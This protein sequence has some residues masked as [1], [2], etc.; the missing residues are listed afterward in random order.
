MHKKG[1][2]LIELLVVIAIIAILAAILLPA[3]ARAREAARRASCQNNLKQLG[4]VLK[5][6]STENKLFPARNYRIGGLNKNWFS[7]VPYVPSFDE[8]GYY[9]GNPRSDWSS[10]EGPGSYDQ[11]AMEE[12]WPDYMNDMNIFACPSDN[13]RPHDFF[14]GPHPLLQADNINPAFQWAKDQAANMQAFMVPIDSN[15]QASIHNDKGYGPQTWLACGSSWS[16]MYYP[17]AIKGEWI[18]NTTNAQEIVRLWTRST[19]T[20]AAGVTQNTKYINRNKD[21]TVTLWPA[22]WTSNINDA[23]NTA[24]TPGGPTVNL[25]R[26]REGI[27]RFFITDINN[28][29]ASTAAQS[30]IVVMHDLTK[31]HQGS[32]MQKQWQFNHIP[33][34]ANILFMDGHVE[35]ARYPS[36]TWGNRLWPVCEAYVRYGNT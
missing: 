20:D 22:S 13:D 16:Y 2:T 11:I 1:F 12:L 6:H 9:S 8:G 33:G 4:L 25:M 19:R 36:G 17:F 24:V 7:T 27:E 35:F 5:M 23:P 21:K 29:A 32:S 30:D 34:G 3:L 28:P 31:V 18:T 14:A 26:L 10:A 15:F